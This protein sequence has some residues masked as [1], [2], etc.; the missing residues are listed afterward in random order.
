[1]EKEIDAILT[2]Y[3]HKDLSRRDSRVIGATWLLR[4][5]DSYSCH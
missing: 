4:L 1:M 3:E 5:S 2:R